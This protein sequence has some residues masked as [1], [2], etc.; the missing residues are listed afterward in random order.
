[1]VVVKYTAEDL[2]LR[3]NIVIVIADLIQCFNAVQNMRKA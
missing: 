2:H 3:I 1:M